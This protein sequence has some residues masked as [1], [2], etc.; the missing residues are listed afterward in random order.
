MAVGGRR[1]Q[2]ARIDGLAVRQEPSG[3]RRTGHGRAETVRS[4]QPDRE[5]QRRPE[6][7]R[8]ARP[9]R[10]VRRGA[11]AVRSA[12]PDREAQ[13]SIKALQGLGASAQ[14]SRLAGT[15]QLATENMTGIAELSQQADRL[16]VDLSAFE[17]EPMPALTAGMAARADREAER[18]A[19]ILATRDATI[20]LADSIKELAAV[21]AQVLVQLTTLAA[22]AAQQTSAARGTRGW[23]LVGVLVAVAV[24]IV[25]AA[26]YFHA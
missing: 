2:D 19:A 14:A 6:T 7:V 26:T 10:E 15:Y 18:D 17:L 20:E 8:S 13:R 24:L 12:W 21:E 1:V 4:A 9:D 23:T 25:A 3:N 16:K 22:E 5:A 11:E